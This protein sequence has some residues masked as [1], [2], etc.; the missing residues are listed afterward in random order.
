[1]MI[2]DTSATISATSP[3]HYVTIKDGTDYRKIA[4]ILSN[5]GHVMNHATARNIL[6]SA[7]TK[8][9]TELGEELGSPISE[10]R[11]QTMINDPNIHSA[12]AEILFVAATEQ[13]NK[14][15]RNP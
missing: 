6:L 14:Q 15:A 1:M 5:K 4:A 3:K 9:I 7:V 2:N 12:L 11:L 8:F 10:E 13:Q